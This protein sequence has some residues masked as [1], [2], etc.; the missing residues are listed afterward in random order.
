MTRKTP[1]AQARKT[2]TRDAQGGAKDPNI[3]ARKIPDAQ[4]GPKDRW[5]P[6][7][8]RPRVARKTPE[9]LA[10]KIPD[11]QDCPKDP[12][13]PCQKDPGRPG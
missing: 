7:P 4:D 11:A 13:H 8:E 1:D 10:R 12:G 9:T 3:L 5:T 6:W 2:K